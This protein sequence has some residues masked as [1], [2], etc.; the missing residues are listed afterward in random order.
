MSAINFPDPSQSPWTNSSTGITYTYSNGVWKALNTAAEQFVKKQDGGVQQVI[1]GGGGLN[2]IGDVKSKSK[3][4]PTAVMGE[5]APASPGVCDFWTDTSSDPPVLKTW[6][7]TEWTAVGSGGGSGPSNDLPA[8]TIM[9]PNVS[10]SNSG[11]APSVLTATPAILNN[12]TIQ[13]TNWYKDG[14]LIAGENGVSYTATVPGVYKYEERH[15]GNDGALVIE[16][17]SATIPVL[18]IDQPTIPSVANGDGS[19]VLTGGIANILPF[20]LDG[21]Q[22]VFPISSI[23]ADTTGLIT[24]WS[25]ADWT[26][27]TDSSFS[28]NVQSSTIPIS[29]SSITQTGP[30]FT[31]EAGT[32]YYMRVKYNSTSPI[33]ESSYSP[34]VNFTTAADTYSISGPSAVDE[35]V[36]STFSVTTS[37]VK[38]GDTLY[39]N[40]T[41]A[42]D[43]N[44]A[45]GSFVVNNSSGT[46]DV[47]TAEDNLLEGTETFQLRLYSD[48]AR[49]N[50]VYTSAGISINDT[51]RGYGQVMYTSPGSY[52]WTVPT[53]VSSIHVV[54]IGA[55]GGGSAGAQP[56]GGGGGGGALAYKNDI[57]VTPGETVSINVGDGG[58]GV[59]YGSAGSGTNSSITTSSSSY[60]MTAGGGQGGQSHDGGPGGT[61]SGNGASGYP[62]GRGGNRAGGGGSGGGGGA[63]GYGGQGGQGG[64]NSSGSNGSGGAG[65]GGGGPN[66][67]NGAY[68]GG[69]YPYG[70]GANGAGGSS[71]PQSG[72]RGS[73]ISGTPLGDATQGKDPGGGGPGGV[74]GPGNA[75]G[76]GLVRIIW[77]EGRS[78]PSTNTV[79]MT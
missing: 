45:V 14:V 15:L 22:T 10:A 42:N 11:Y 30:I 77:G 36:T 52:T 41:D 53:S 66:G 7:G 34:T 16:E 23:P 76:D 24:T 35:G 40:T 4:I 70:Q 54:M 5:N 8:Q 58:A 46:F 73:F 69:T 68:G 51:S 59:R 48:S 43:F 67:S 27:A 79:D 18:N 78:F 49:T 13:I 6:N 65:G 56:G 9:G 3:T 25:N 64:S 29:D 72:G 1:S 39:W 44:P 31:Y 38:N 20:D 19:N 62:G 50:L 12:A 26:L 37:N 57:A 2:I 60:T 75:G 74:W 17:Y 21:N 71:S 61:A 33:G 63:G 55:G 47:T 32:D 28:A